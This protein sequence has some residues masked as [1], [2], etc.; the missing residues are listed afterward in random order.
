MKTNG[1]LFLILFTFPALT[2]C[3]TVY[4]VGETT[5]ALSLYATAD[6]FGPSIFTI[7]SSERV[8]IKKRSKPYSHL[9]YE[10]YEGY[11]YNPQF[12]NVHRYNPKKDGILYSYPIIKSTPSSTE[13]SSSGGGTVQVKGYTKKNGT[14]VSPHT[15]SA[16]SR[17]H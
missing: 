4:Y 16:P 1:L 11:V 12:A 10:N 2:S 5:R 7:P 13:K 3:K 6:D 17:R 15:R 9:V 14:Y 8:L